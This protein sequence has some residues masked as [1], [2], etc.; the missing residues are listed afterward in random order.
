[1]S[2]DARRPHAPHRRP[3]ARAVVGW[4]VWRVVRERGALVLRSAVYDETWQP[5]TAVDAACARGHAAPS[6]ACECGIYAVREPA[7]ALRYLVGRNDADVVHRVVGEVV[8]W[9]VAVEGEHGWRAAHAYPLRLWIPPRQTSGFAV[10]TAEI[11]LG[12]ARYGVPL[13][14]LGAHEPSEIVPELAAA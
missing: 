1:L 10:D 14:T 3:R 12:L 5:H 2:S 6:P 7:A 4:R 13:A 9:G 11:A 8:L